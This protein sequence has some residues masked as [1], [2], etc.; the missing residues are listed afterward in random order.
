M[1]TPE[2]F[3]AAVAARLVHVMHRLTHEN[4]NALVDFATVLILNQ[5]LEAQGA[6]AEALRK[7]L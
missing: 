3:D 2:H 1:S 5:Q 6:H 7:A 4:R